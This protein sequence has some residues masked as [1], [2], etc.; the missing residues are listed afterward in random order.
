MSGS[1]S[2]RG[3]SASTYTLRSR[4]APH[5]H[6]V[7]AM[8]IHSKIAKFSSSP[9]SLPASKSTM[10]FTIES[11]HSSLLPPAC[12]FNS[13]TSRMQQQHLEAS[14][15]S[16]PYAKNTSREI[17]SST[18][19]GIKLNQV[20]ISEALQYTSLTLAVCAS[21]TVLGINGLLGLPF[22][23][24]MLLTMLYLSWATY[25]WDHLRDCRLVS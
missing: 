12:C 24:P 4:Q 9:T 8:I 22:S 18:S 19:L 2:L 5:R 11:S 20:S 6:C 14:Q 23:L 13:E 21:S 16:Q 3:L 7:S 25:L 10:N 17:T 15:A 1:T